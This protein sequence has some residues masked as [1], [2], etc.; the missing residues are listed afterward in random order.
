MGAELNYDK[1]SVAHIYCIYKLLARMFHLAGCVWDTRSKPSTSGLVLSE[2]R[3]L[4]AYVHLWI[5][6]WPVVELDWVQARHVGESAEESR[7]VLAFK[8][9]NRSQEKKNR[10]TTKV[11]TRCNFASHRVLC[12]AG[13][14]CFSFSCYLFLVKKASSGFLGLGAFTDH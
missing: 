5:W 1:W 8:T 11:S 3:W 14:L 6:I 4:L 7:G 9:G 2:V 13:W 10:E 12:T